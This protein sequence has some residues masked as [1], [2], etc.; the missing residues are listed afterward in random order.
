MQHM[1]VTIMDA[2]KMP[3]YAKRDSE[4]RSEDA[5]G[6]LRTSSS[7]RCVAVLPRQ[8]CVKRSIAD[9]GLRRRVCG[10]A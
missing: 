7:P 5:S 10:T 9:D 3:T 1:Y 2:T 4:L 6:R 8:R